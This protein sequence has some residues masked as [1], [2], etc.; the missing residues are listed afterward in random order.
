VR[1]REGEDADADRRDDDRELDPGER[2]ERARKREKGSVDRRG[3]EGKRE[4]DAL[5]RSL[6]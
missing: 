1:V 2:C 4:A 3:R 5:V 6:A